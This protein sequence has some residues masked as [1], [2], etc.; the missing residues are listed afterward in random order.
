MKIEKYKG[1][2]NKIVND[3]T[4]IASDAFRRRMSAG[5]VKEHLKGGLLYLLLDSGEMKGFALFE[6][7]GDILYLKGIAV[8]EDYQ[9]HDFFYN[10]ISRELPKYA[11]FSLRT[12]SPVM[13]NA[14]KNLVKRGL[15]KGV[16]PPGGESVLE[17]LLKVKKHLGMNGY[18]F[19]SRRFYGGPLYGKEYAYKGKLIDEFIPDFNSS[20]GDAVILI[21]A[22]R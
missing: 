10:V 3:A 18:S 15:L 9:Q 1:P 14:T 2:V 5:E 20:N 16:Y 11:Y 17:I 12:Q 21:G 8:E 4:K 22:V 7:L 13:Y 6:D 19:I